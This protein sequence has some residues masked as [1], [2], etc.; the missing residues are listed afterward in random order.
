MA[1]HAPRFK[2]YK[3]GCCCAS[4]LSKIPELRGI[5]DRRGRCRYF[6]TETRLC[7]IY[8]NRPEMCDVERSYESGYSEVPWRDYC[9]TQM[10]N[11][12]ALRYAQGVEEPEGSPFAGMQEAIA[13]QVMEDHRLFDEGKLEIPVEEE[14][15]GLVCTSDEDSDSADKTNDDYLYIDVD[16]DDYDV[17]DDYDEDYPDDDDIIIDAS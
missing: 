6:D 8:E 11:C 5:A 7:Q 2:C 9:F 13:L 3:C 12:V 10:L 15:N 14:A 17:Q 16:Y 1:R 4:D